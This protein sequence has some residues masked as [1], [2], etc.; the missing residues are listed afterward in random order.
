MEVI[1]GVSHR[2]D[3]ST[4]MFAV[5]PLTQP[6][7]SVII[8]RLVGS[9]DR[10]QGEVIS[11]AAQGSIQFLNHRVHRLP[12]ET[13]LSHLADFLADGADSLFRGAR[14]DKGSSRA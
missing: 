3:A 2:A 11:P 10:A 13:P 14:A 8:Y 1:G 5:Q 6:V 4:G 9:T 7:P 12:L